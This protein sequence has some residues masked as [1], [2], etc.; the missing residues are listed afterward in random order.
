MGDDLVMSSWQLFS[1]VLLSTLRDIGPIVLIVLFFQLVVLRRAFT[2]LSKLLAG[3][4]CV[5]FGLALFLIGL[6]L[7]LF[8]L[9]ESMAMQLASPQFIAA[10]LS[11]ASGETLTDS[12]AWYDYYWVYLFAFS[13]GVSTTIAEPALIAVASKASEVSGGAIRE[14]ELRLVVALGVGIGVAVGTLRII[15]GYPLP[16]FI[17]PG[18]LFVILQTRFAPKAI[19]PIAYDSGGVTT[20]TVTVPI[21]AALGLGLATQI[22]GADPLIDGF[23]LIAFASLFPIITVMGYA[24]LAAWWSQRGAP[25][26]RIG[27]P[28]QGPIVNPKLSSKKGGTTDAF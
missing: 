11:Q 15:L 2:D 3:V 9:G 20:S 27:T 7:A 10:D 5:V 6:E 12:P 8:P 17:L 25:T 13:I 22:E 16:Y 18:Y 14:K 28:T 21:V 26:A 1:G 4:V 24:Q 19:I 23:G